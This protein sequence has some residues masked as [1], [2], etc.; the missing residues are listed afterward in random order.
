VHDGDLVVADQDGCVAVPQSIEDE[1]IRLA[2]QKVSDENQVR[3]LLRRGASI[4][5]V[6]RDHGIL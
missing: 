3:D 4:R 5:Q 1:A 6:F 2:M